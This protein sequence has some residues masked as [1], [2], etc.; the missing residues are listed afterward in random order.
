[1]F[2]SG[3]VQGFLPYH[4]FYRYSTIRIFSEDN[5]FRFIEWQPQYIVVSIQMLKKDFLY[6]KVRMWADQIKP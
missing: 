6:S 5:T 3:Q 4:R 2:D 1:M